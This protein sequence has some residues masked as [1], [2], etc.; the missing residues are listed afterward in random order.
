M[1][2]LNNFSPLVLLA[3]LSVC[4]SRLVVHRAHLSLYMALLSLYM[5]LL[6]RN[7]ARSRQANAEPEQFFTTGTLG[8]F[9][10]MRESLGCA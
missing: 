5:A 7:T 8:S 9:Q 3:R 10:C 2:S 1:Q 6:R 4:G